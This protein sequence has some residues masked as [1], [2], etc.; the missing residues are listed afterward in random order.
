MADAHLATCERCAGLALQH[1]V[2]HRALS[3]WS[4]PAYVDPAAVNR[5]WVFLDEL[6]EGRAG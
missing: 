3:L 6:T 5:V 4:G 1:R 2:L